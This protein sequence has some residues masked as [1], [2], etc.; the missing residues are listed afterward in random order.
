MLVEKFEPDDLQEITLLVKKSTI[1]KLEY[2]TSIDEEI[3]D[4]MIENLYEKFKV[5]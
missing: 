2:L 5:E 1:K 4:V 3:L